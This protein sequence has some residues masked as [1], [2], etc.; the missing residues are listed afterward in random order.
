MPCLIG[1][2]AR[3]VFFEH[4]RAA[5]YEIEQCDIGTSGIFFVPDRFFQ[6][7]GDVV[8]IRIEQRSDAERRFAAELSD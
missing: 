1:N 3:C 8:S 2:Q 7:L 5:L 6:D 4:D